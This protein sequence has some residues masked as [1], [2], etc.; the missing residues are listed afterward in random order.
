MSRLCRLNKIPRGDFL[1]KLVAATIFRTILVSQ[2]ARALGNLGHSR[3]WYGVVSG[4]VLFNERI[5]GGGSRMHK[6]AVTIT[7]K[8]L[9]VLAP[10]NV[11]AETTT[12][13]CATLS[14]LLV[15]LYPII[16]RLLFN[17]V[18][19]GTKRLS[20]IVKHAA[21]EIG[22]LGAFEA[23]EELECSQARWLVKV[24]LLFGL[25]LSVIFVVTLL[26]L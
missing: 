19:E 24:L 2:Q 26:W 18:N 12:S 6:G 14:L 3:P 4:S 20:E 8:A 21:L 16:S 9:S 15:E 11:R 5:V 7:A 22:H 23:Y 10:E 13:I 17:P 1:L 25:T